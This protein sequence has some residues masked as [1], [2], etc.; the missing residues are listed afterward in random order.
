MRFEFQ[1]FSSP[2][3]VDRLYFAGV[4]ARKPPVFYGTG[5]PPDRATTPIPIARTRIGVR[6][7]DAP[8]FG[9]VSRPSRKTQTRCYRAVKTAAGGGTAL[10]CPA[11]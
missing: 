8:K 10:C 4:V 9:E 2:P 7:F 5:F 6:K 11:A 3:P 1:V